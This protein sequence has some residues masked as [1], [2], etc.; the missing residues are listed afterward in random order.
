MSIEKIDN[1]QLR[2][3][4]A[5]INNLTLRKV[6]L[7]F[8]FVVGLVFAYS[9]Y[10]NK[11][12]IPDLV[13]ENPALLYGFLGV[14]ALLAVGNMI[15]NIHNRVDESRAALLSEVRDRM[16]DQSDSHKDSM[17]SLQLQIQDLRQREKDCDDRYNALVLDLAKRGVYKD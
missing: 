11:H 4:A 9:M 14:V 17:N 10:E 5:F 3:W 6:L 8:V 2:G 13:K 12:S 15:G 16:K 1:E 7:T